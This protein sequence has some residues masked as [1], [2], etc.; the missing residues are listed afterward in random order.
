MKLYEL[1]QSYSFDEIMP[2][3]LKMFP[4]TAKY[5]E[6][7]KQAYDILVEMRPVS[8]KKSIRYRF[9]NM[10]NSG[11]SYMG[12][13]DSDFRCTWE[14]CLGKDVVRERGIDLS[15]AEILA[16]CLVNICFIGTHPRR[17]DTAYAELTRP[18]R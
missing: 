13:A 1:I 10:D 11:E 2:E 14:V 7:L 17:F 12:A 18:E 5:R 3:I 8:S 16:N 4:G 9:F 6:P 15:D